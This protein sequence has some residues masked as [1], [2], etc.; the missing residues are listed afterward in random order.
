MTMG[1]EL[2]TI[3]SKAIAPLLVDTALDEDAAFG[4]DSDPFDGAIVIGAAN[5]LV[6]GAAF[7]EI[8][9]ER[10]ALIETEMHLGLF[11]CC[12]LGRRRCG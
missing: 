5:W 1:S 12:L 9:A 7:V 6:S 10:L 8:R 4:S 11:H 2:M 3:G